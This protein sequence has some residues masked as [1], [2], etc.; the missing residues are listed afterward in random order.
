M[1]ARGNAQ[2]RNGSPHG[3]WARAC[4]GLAGALLFPALAACHPSAPIVTQPIE[5]WLP[6]LC[7]EPRPVPADDFAKL[8]ARLL[9]SWLALDDTADDDAGVTVVPR[10][11]ANGSVRDLEIDYAID[12]S[13]IDAVEAELRAAEPLAVYRDLLR[14]MP[15]TPITDL[16]S[17]LEQNR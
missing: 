11:D 5:P 9:E 17:L 16:A 10:L 7:L 4:R 14:C 3:T 12:T 15:S 6:P 8:E 13:P 1:H 2:H